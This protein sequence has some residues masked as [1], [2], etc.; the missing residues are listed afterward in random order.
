MPPT[1]GYKGVI[2]TWMFIGSYIELKILLSY[3]EDAMLCIFQ[4]HKCQR[5]QKINKAYSCVCC[6]T[7]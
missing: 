7:L 5:N 2:A 1:V 6:L 4:L 3:K